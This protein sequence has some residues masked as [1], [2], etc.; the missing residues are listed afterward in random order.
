M[1]NAGD[2]FLNRPYS[3][4]HVLGFTRP[5]SQYDTFVENNDGHSEYIVNE[6]RNYLRKWKQNN[7][8]N[9]Q[10]EMYRHIKDSITAEQRQQL[11][12]HSFPNMSNDGGAFGQGC[13]G[14]GFLSEIPCHSPSYPY[15]FMIFSATVVFFIPLS[16]ASF[17]M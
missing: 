1:N 15:V 6:G 9:L 11:C 8:A 5:N 12:C 7:M 10:E 17:S 4:H 3:L 13:Y 14:R 16:I 2:K